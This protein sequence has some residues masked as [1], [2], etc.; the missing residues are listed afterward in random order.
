M[1]GEALGHYR[2]VEKLAE[3]G[4]G[5]MLSWKNPD[6]RMAILTA[7]PSLEPLQLELNSLI[8][9]LWVVR[10]NLI[11]DDLQFDHSPRRPTD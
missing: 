5:P 1:I 3:G 9:S 6:G 10:S 8:T 7:T 2:I 11:E 4:A